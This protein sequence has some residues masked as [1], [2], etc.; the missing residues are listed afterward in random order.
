MSG[1]NKWSTIKH[2]KGKTD[3]QRARVFTKIGREIAIA[4]R[5]GG[6]NPDNNSKLRDV[7][8]KAKASNMPNDNINRSI[9]K[10]AGEGS[11]VNYEEIT[12]EGY[13]AGG[14]AVI[15]ETLT[16]NRNR[17]ASDVRH[18]FDKFGGSMGT[19]GCVAWMFDHKGVL[20]IERTAEMDE[21]EVMMA[22]LDAGAQDF[23]AGEE[24]FE[25]QTG[26]GEFSSVR[27]A[28]EQA[29]YSFISA[30]ISWVPQQDPMEVS[31]DVEQKLEILIDRLEELDDVQAV[32]HNADM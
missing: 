29:G 17:T 11:G 2:K 1:H 20:V 26:I 31:E 6:P 25:I 16:D 14:V 15:V 13:G 30:E 23:D 10:A 4:V 22:A 27:E 21:D 28:L 8:A 5:E 19:S 9:Q 3:A 24:A 7:I 32:Y 12:Y 18:I